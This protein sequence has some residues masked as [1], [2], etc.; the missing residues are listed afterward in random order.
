MN[1]SKGTQGT[2]GSTPRSKAGFTLVE[3]LLVLVILGLLAAIVVPKFAGRTEQ[4][5]ITAAR[6]QIASFETVLDAFEI[7]NGYYPEGSDGLTDL[8]H[9]PDNAPNWNGPYL[10]EIPLDPWENAYLYTYPG[11]EN[12]NGYDLMSL[13]PDGRSGNEDDIKNWKD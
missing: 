5:K 9:Q 6:T 2:R 10:K 12:E 3:L 4:A 13:G 11:E 8:V 1:P 7:D